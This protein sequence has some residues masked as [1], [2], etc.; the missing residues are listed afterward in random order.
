MQAQAM[1]KNILIK[2]TEIRN[3]QVI[4]KHVY[5]HSFLS[6]CRIALDLT[7]PNQ[8]I[9]LTSEKEN[10]ENLWEFVVRKALLY[11]WVLTQ[12]PRGLLFDCIGCINILM[13]L[14]LCVYRKLF[15]WKLRKW[16]HKIWNLNSVVLVTIKRV[17]P[18]YLQFLWILL[19]KNR[20]IS[21]S[22]CRLNNTDC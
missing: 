20:R 1:R 12:S 2:E 14:F 5:V 8:K 10:Y 17:F 7:Q 13:I 15:H 19:N 16:S 21:I 18:N 22:L 11:G 9:I 6:L 3:P 4:L